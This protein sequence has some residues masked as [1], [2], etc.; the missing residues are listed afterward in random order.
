MGYDKLIKDHYEDLNNL[1]N[2]LTNS[3]NAYRLLISSAAELNTINVAKKGSIKEAVERVDALGDI[4]DD[5]LKGIKKC[6]EPYIKYCNIRNNVISKST[7]KNVILTEIDTELN[8][9]NR[10]EYEAEYED[11]YEED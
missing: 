9:Q 1:S 2:L 3:V 8:Y 5:L 6:E 4:I 7:Q 10:D 11:S